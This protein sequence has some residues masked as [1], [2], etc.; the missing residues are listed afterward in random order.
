MFLVELSAALLLPIGDGKAIE[1]RGASRINPFEGNGV[2]CSVGLEG[3]LHEWDS[4]GW[5]FTT[6]SEVG[7][8]SL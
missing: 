8:L 1:T 7:S 5:L 3:E 6:A 4:V 2:T